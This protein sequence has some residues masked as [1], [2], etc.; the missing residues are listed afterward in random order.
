MDK[1]ADFSSHHIPLKLSQLLYLLGSV[2]KGYTVSKP[3]VY[4]LLLS[5][6]DVIA[7]FNTSSIS[8]CYYCISDKQ[9]QK[10]PHYKQ[11]IG[12][13]LILKNIRLT[14]TVRKSRKCSILKSSSFFRAR[15]LFHGKIFDANRDFWIV[16]YGITKN[17]FENYT[18]N[19][20]KILLHGRAFSNLSI[21]LNQLWSLF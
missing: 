2:S 7:W 8:R 13:L 12:L 19:Q 17:V 18:S 1:I 6:E 10:H 15:W 4:C 16:K 11:K 14:I 9:N 3:A 20:F 5:N 21:Q